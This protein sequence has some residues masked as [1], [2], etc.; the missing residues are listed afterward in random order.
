MT[1]FI[2]NHLRKIAEKKNVKNTNSLGKHKKKTAK[3]MKRNCEEIE[4]EVTDEDTPKDD[5]NEKLEKGAEPLHTTTPAETTT[6]IKDTNLETET[7]SSVNASQK[8]TS[9]FLNPNI[10]SNKAFGR[11]LSKLSPTEQKSIETIKKRRNSTMLSMVLLDEI[12]DKI[13]ADYVTSRVNNNSN[14]AQQMTQKGFFFGKSRWDIFE[15]GIELWKDGPSGPVLQIA[16]TRI[17]YS[18]TNPGIVDTTCSLLSYVRA[19]V[20]R[21]FTDMPIPLYQIFQEYWTNDSG[22]PVYKSV[23]I[24]LG[25]L[26]SPDIFRINQTDILR[27]RVGFSPSIFLV[28]NTDDF[29]SHRR[30]RI[31][32]NPTIYHVGY[33]PEKK[34]DPPSIPTPAKS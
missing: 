27:F 32:G 30:Y 23:M 21:T 28:G 4:E 9:G 17:P 25:P 19:H 11:D 13:L 8:E 31:Q 26:Q 24:A 6:G 20:N 33:N 29:T 3:S 5:V 15:L 16:W 1:H 7:P 18:K 12:S 10:I 14:F 2:P 34:S 22:K